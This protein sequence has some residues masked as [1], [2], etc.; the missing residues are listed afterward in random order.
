MRLAYILYVYYKGM[1]VACR[2]YVFCK[3]MR[4]KFIEFV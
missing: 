4:I 3:G 2:G 1:R